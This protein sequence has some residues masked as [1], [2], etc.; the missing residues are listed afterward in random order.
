MKRLFAS[1]AL[2]ATVGLASASAQTISTG[3]ISQDQ[4]K[5]QK[6]HHP[7]GPPPGCKPPGAASTTTATNTTTATG[8]AGER[9]GPPPIGQG[10]PFGHH[11]PPRG[12]QQGGTQQG[13]TT[14][15]VTQ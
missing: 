7:M 2:L 9:C 3:D 5:G 13:V 11:G 12:G 6:H 8:T 1:L 4:F 15:T 14:T 10:Q